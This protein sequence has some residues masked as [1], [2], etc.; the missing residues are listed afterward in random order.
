MA[1]YTVLQNQ[2]ISDCILNS[3]GDITAWSDFLNSN[4]LADWVPNLFSGQILQVPDNTNT[5]VGN[6]SALTDYPANNFS[7]SDIYNQIDDL[8]ASLVGLTPI[9]S[10]NVLPVLNDQT[11]YTVRQGEGIGDVTMNSS[12]DFQNLDLVTQYAFFDT[13]TPDLFSGQQI[14]IPS[15]INL[16]SNNYRALNTYP[17]NNFSTP[18]IYEQIAEL[19]AFLGGG[20]LWILR[21]GEWIDFPSFWIDHDVWID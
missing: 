8:F 7:F 2:S 16:D 17:A 13:W 20:D 1:T 10:A 4:F 12:G 3:C 19:F 5:N 15:T 6:I 14:P 11:F 9:P 21:T 18:D